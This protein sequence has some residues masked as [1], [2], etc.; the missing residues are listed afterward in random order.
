MRARPFFPAPI[1]FLA[2]QEN[3]KTNEA[4]LPPSVPSNP[5][6]PFDACFAVRQIFTLRAHQ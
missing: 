3:L 5:L 6:T 4:P 2:I 1:Y